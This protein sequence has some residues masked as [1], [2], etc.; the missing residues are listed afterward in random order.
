VAPGKKKRS[1]PPLPGAAGVAAAA[2]PWSAEQRARVRAHS[3]LGPR[4]YTIL[5]RALELEEEREALRALAR[6]QP[7][8]TNP[9]RPPPPPVVLATETETKWFLPQAQA[10][11]LFGRPARARLPFC[12]PAELPPFPAFAQRL[13]PAQLPVVRLCAEEILRQALRFSYAGAVLQLGCGLGKTVIGIY[14]TVV[15]VPAL[16][17]AAA[18]WRA[19]HPDR[20]A[21]LDA[22]DTAAA[23]MPAL[24]EVFPE[25]LLADLNRLL[26]GGNEGS[27]GSALTMLPP[28]PP[29]QPAAPVLVL[30]NSSM[31]LGQW[32]KRIETACPGA[33]V[34]EIR[35]K[36]HEVAGCHFVLGMIQT[37]WSRTYAPEAFAPFR[38]VIV[39]EAHR[40]C[41]LEYFKALRQVVAPAIVALSA[42]VQKPNGMEEVLFRFVG[43]I[44]FRSPVE[45]TAYRVTVRVVQFASHSDPEYSRV[46]YTPKGELDYTATI[47]RVSMYGP[48][49]DAAADTL[50]RFAEQNPDRQILVLSTLKDPLRELGERIQ[51][52]NQAGQRRRRALALLPAAAASAD[53]DASTPSAPSA[54]AKRRRSEDED[55]FATKRRRLCDPEDEDVLATKRRRHGDPE[56][57]EEDAAASSKRRRLDED[58]AVVVRGADVDEDYDNI[59]EDDGRHRPTFGY[60]IGGMKPDKLDE[61]SAAQIILATYSMAAEGLDIPSLDALFLYNAKAT[62]T[63]PIGR[64]MRCMNDHK[65]IYDFVDSHQ[66]FQSQ[67]FRK[68]MPVY[69][70]NGYHVYKTAYADLAAAPRAASGPDGHSCWQSMYRPKQQ[71]QQRQEPP[72]SAARFG[73]A[74]CGDAD[75]DEGDELHG[76]GGFGVVGSDGEEEDT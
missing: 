38:A 50:L 63:Q 48:R 76:C 69:R 51:A 74:G 44:A 41:S 35:G 2:Y 6:F 58:G 37:M 12:P 8:S 19:K 32:R 73:S 66:V 42:T 60:Y 22:D 64:P 61:S 29:E 15:L 33:R 13:L 18:A 26:P 11:A 62:I 70:G 68:R 31:L 17:A 56:D 14:M 10:L 43:P 65:V 4:G 71:Q 55:A 75:D 59:D 45:P 20:A 39:D 7:L 47:G 52:W 9:S 16:L 27:G 57:E 67:L 36:K 40:I 30:L 46:D 54:P 49:L 1:A 24:G 3:Y 23:A 5:A 28:L 21:K 34:G 53:E 72:K 25:P